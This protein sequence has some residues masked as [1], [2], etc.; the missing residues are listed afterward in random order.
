[1]TELKTLKDIVEKRAMPRGNIVFDYNLRAEAIKWI[2]KHNEVFEDDGF[3]EF[4]QMQARG[5]VYWIK[6]FFNIT[7]EDL[8][9][10]QTK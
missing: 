9:G 8:K 5:A 7:E 6:H 3:D 10:E 1:M 4:E 2:K